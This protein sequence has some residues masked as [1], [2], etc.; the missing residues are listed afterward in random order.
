MEV[1]GP[2][3]REKLLSDCKRK[4][5]LYKRTVDNMFRKYGMEYEKFKEMNIVRALNYA[6]EAESDG[7]LWENA[8]EGIAMLQKKIELMD[9]EW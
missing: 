2:C 5:L 3:F 8:I 1:S 9:M 6:W 7:R 4:I